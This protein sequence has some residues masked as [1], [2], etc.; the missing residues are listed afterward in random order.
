MFKTKLSTTKIRLIVRVFLWS[1]FALLF[2]WV[3]DKNIVPTGKMTATYTVPKG[4]RLFTNVMSKDAERLTGVSKDGT[5]VPFLYVTKPPLL[6]DV[7]TPRSFAKATVRVTY[8]NPG[9]QS[10]LRVGIEQADTR[11]FYRDLAVTEPAL[12]ALPAWWQR[13]SNGTLTL[14]ERNVGYEKKVAQKA[15][16]KTR[17]QDQIEKKYQQTR[18]SLAR[19]KENRLISDDVYYK[20]TQEVIDRHDKD[21]AALDIRYRTLPP[22]TEE[23]PYTTVEDFLQRIPD[24]QRTLR[25]NTILPTFPLKNYAPAA[26]KTVLS[27][28][29]RGSHKIMTYVGKGEKL[30]YAFTLQDINRRA[31]ADSF[32][33]SVSD[34]NKPIFSK[35]IV[36][37]G[38]DQAIEVP[39]KEQTM[40]LEKAD[41]PEG[42]YTLHIQTNEDVIIKRIE[43]AQRYIMFAGSLYLA[44]NR[45]YQSVLNK[46]TYAS[47]TV[48]TD[49][50]TLSAVTA[51]TGGLQTLTVGS[52]YLVVSKI[53]DIQQT[54]LFSPITT[55]VALKNDV[56]LSGDGY[57][58]FSR[59]QM[60]AL[61]PQ[62]NTFSSDVDIS[63]YD[64]IIASYPEPQKKGDWLLAQTTLTNEMHTNKNHIVKFALDIPDLAENHLAVKILSIQVTFE[65]QALTPQYLW[66]KASNALGKLFHR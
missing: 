55:I 60:F 46:N 8:Q 35:K 26:T 25:Y 30:S 53:Q 17:Q 31:G 40:L 64:Y 11:F 49:G 36:S 65:K 12:D 18:T 21:L 56:K 2:G 59:E 66:T 39:S 6:F 62:Y 41:L 22:V 28:S 45:E 15:A 47:T 4:G 27:T 29:L 5:S 33:V 51:H 43:T 34:V 44:E 3:L 16:E 9:N 38:I 23:L 10:K 19:D 54:K 1:A 37:V 32:T 48:Y 58:A 24:P 63:G 50:T 13:I 52:S 7:F 14:W 42:V 20:K 57:F 61:P